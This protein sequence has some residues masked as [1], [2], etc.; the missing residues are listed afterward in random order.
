MRVGG[1]FAISAAAMPELEIPLR[2]IPLTP[3]AP[4][5]LEGELAPSPYNFHF[6][7]E[8][9]LRLTTWNAAA[10]VRV[11]VHGRMWHP[12]RGIS[13]FAFDQAP[14]TDRSSRTSLF[15]P[16]EGYLLNAT[17]FCTTGTP[18]WGQ[19]FARL[20]VVRGFSGGITVLGTLVQGFCVNGQDLAWPGS[21]IRGATD[22]GGYPRYIEGTSPAAGA[23]ILE[24][25]PS[26]A[27]WELR[28]IALPFTTAAG[29]A[30]RTVTIRFMHQLSMIWENTSLAQQ[31]PASTATHIWAIGMVHRSTI[32]GARGILH[33]LPEGILLRGAEEIIS[34]TVNIQA[35]DQFGTPI[36]ELVERVEAL[37]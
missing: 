23:E 17:V 15:F 33:T 21:P 2:E 27:A 31:S 11:G 3:A 14:N 24:A 12:Q 34:S 1:R 26:G 29:G 20:N 35:G 13:T 5:R 28:S 6:T 22:P 36:L 32:L 19:L 4:A 37:S 16:G 30:D 7:G 10:A 8:D 18:L 25:V 9:S